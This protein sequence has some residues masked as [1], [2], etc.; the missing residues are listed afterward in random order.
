MSIAE[1]VLATR[2]KKKKRKE[3]YLPYAFV[4]S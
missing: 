1:S 3:K 2:L 4:S